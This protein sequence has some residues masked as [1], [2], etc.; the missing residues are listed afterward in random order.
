MSE[1]IQ[2]VPAVV[3]S[4]IV[5]QLRIA[6]D[7]QTEATKSLGR[8]LVDRFIA[9]ERFATLA[10]NEAR[11]ILPCSLTRRLER[12]ARGDHWPALRA[13]VSADR[14]LVQ[15]ISRSRAFREAAI[16][17]ASIAALVATCSAARAAANE[18]GKRFRLAKRGAPPVARCAGCP[19]LQRQQRAD[20]V[21]VS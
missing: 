1:T 12:F 3:D 8:S 9:D 7:R 14:R 15:L 19:E 6:V 5:Q 13:K 2:Q 18:A 16:S 21:A 4:A 11:D 20:G 17:D 10:V